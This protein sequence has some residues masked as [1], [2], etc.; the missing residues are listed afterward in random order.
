[1]IISFKSVD[2]DLW[3]TVVVLY[4]GLN[5]GE[6]NRISSSKMLR[7]FGTHLRSTNVLIFLIYLTMLTL[8]LKS[9]DAIAETSKVDQILIYEAL[10]EIE[11][12]KK[13]K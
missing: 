9:E 3:K 5:D 13:I 6:L 7:I 11:S 1:M 10:E 8:C 4:C 2:Y 12:Q